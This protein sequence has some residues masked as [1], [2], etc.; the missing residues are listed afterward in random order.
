VILCD[1]DREALTKSED[2]LRKVAGKDVVSVRGSMSPTSSRRRALRAA[3]VQFG[4]ID[5]CVSMPG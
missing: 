5:I 3:S 2:S 1:I 4:G